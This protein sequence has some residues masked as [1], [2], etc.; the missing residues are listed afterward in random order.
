MGASAQRLVEVSAESRKHVRA[1]VAD[2]VQLLLEQPSV[3]YAVVGMLLVASSAVTLIPGPLAVDAG[4][5]FIA[6]V[7][8]AALA[9]GIREGMFVAALSSILCA[10]FTAM[11][12]GEIDS[13]V[14]VGLAVARFVVYGSTAA[15]LGAFAEAHTAVQSHLRRL[16]SIDPL[17]KVANVASFH[18]HLGLLEATRAEFAVLLIDVDNLKAVN[19]RHG[20]QAGTAAIQLVAH[21]LRAI[22]RASDHIA[23]YG[24]DEFVVV[25]ADSHRSGAER[26][27]ARLRTLLAE[28]EIGGFDGVTVQVSAGVAVRGEDGTTPEELLAVAD[29]AMYS[30]KRAR[31]ALR[32]A[33]PEAS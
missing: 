25:L 27:V 32:L 9:R 3:R 1:L 30:D 5:M 24:G 14:V 4:W 2:Q 29:A 16:A 19:D 12:A 7:A 23:R 6:P 28:E 21:K 20:H 11:V 17:T 18:H 26:V 31:K 22:V 10:T 8:V 13:A 15:L 33:P